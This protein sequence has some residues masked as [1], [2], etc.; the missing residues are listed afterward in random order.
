MTS[1]PKPPSL[2][3]VNPTAEGV[4][5]SGIGELIGYGTD[6]PGLIPLWVGEGDRPTP[7]FI[8]EAAARALR[9]GQTFYTRMLGI[10]ELREAIAAY[11]ARL[12]GGAAEPD[13]IFVTVGGMQAFDIALKI[14]AVPGDE[15]VVPTPTW[16]NFFGAIEASGAHRVMVPMS[17]SP[18][19]GWALDIERLAA[20]VTAR[21]RVLVVNS[22]ANPTGWTATHA[23]LRALLA[24]ARRHDL[25]IIA[26]EIY[27][28]FSFDPAHAALG[29]APS[30]RDVWEPEDRDRVL[31]VQ[32]FS[33]NWA[34]T[35][36][37]IGWLEGPAQLGRIVD[38]LI[39]YGTSGIA[40][41]L[42]HAAVVA[43]RDGE[44]LVQAQIAQAREGRRILAE[45]L[46]RLPGV[47]LPP[48]AGAFYAFPRI[49]GEPDARHLAMRLV[50]EANVG[51]APGTA[52]GPGG[53]SFLRLCFARSAGDLHEAV[54]RL[55]PVLAAGR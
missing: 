32:T 24:I 46:G 23:D 14:A 18:A 30:I 44:P 42:Q 9:D 40:T 49:P 6:R 35:G 27:G 10:P 17:F 51:V 16:P 41:F 21:T 4:L 36:W 29:R 11:I 31:F 55:A 15:V 53:Q 43:V 3:P 8:G 54:R 48:P 1:M 45:G 26:D 39:L 28:R 25:W 19:S 50:D 20:A 12:Y 7:D 37:R 47:E 2:P 22:P 38:G 13:R 5:P 34:M 33:K 52:F